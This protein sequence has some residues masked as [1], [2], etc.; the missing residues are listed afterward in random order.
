MSFD[1]EYVFKHSLTDY[2][3]YVLRRFTSI[4]IPLNVSN[5]SFDEI[6]FSCHLQMGGI[7]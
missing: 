2:G 5:N 1:K 7:V 3:M 4:S 6:Y